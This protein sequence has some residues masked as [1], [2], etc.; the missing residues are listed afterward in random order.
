MA[1]P[2]AGR[3]AIPLLVLTILVACGQA[4]LSAQPAAA[5]IAF[6]QKGTEASGGGST[7]TATLPAATTAGDL[8]VATVQDINSGCSSDNFTAPSGWTKAAHVCRG[9]TGPLELWY[10][11]NTAAGTTSVTFNTGSSGANSLAQLSEWSGVATTS[12][13]DQTG[14]Q[15][16]GSASTTLGV[17][18]SSS[19][20]ASGELAV[21][22][23]DTS[24]GLSSFTAG[25]GWTNL[26]SDP[27]NGFDSD[28]RLNPTSG[29]VLSESPTSSPQTTWG[30]AIATFLP[31]CAGGSLTIKTSPTL[32]FPGVTLN[33][34]NRSTSTTVAITADDESG[35]GSGWNLNAT[36]TTFSDGS[37]HS[38]PTTAT[39]FTAASASAATGNCSLPTNTTSY[40]VTL[41]AGSTP[42]TAAKLFN[43]SAGTG[44]GPANLS[45]TANLAV[46]ANTR[47]G[48][49]SS[50]W[51]FTLSSG[52]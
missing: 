22:G 32:T 29:S 19:I 23:F 12:P 27:G 47:A 52:P 45:L 35:S 7:I 18:T 17:S 42:P 5:A 24:S 41:P 34:Y 26:R 2:L 14:T 46:P 20:A 3:R 43:A 30:G 9:S 48:S 15:S 49:Y 10:L 37:G 16:S 33:A 11:P 36:S 50:T 31:A 1:A 6:V 4:L 8:L 38:L 13:L 39:T 51:T 28:Y 40:P 25:T 44:A 21:T